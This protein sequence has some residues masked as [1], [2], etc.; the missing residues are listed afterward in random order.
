[1]SGGLKSLLWTPCF[2][3]GARHSPGPF[4]RHRGSENCAGPGLLGGQ[5]EEAVS[6]LITTFSSV[7]W[8]ERLPW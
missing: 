1:M 3:R 5:K 2:F 6:P 7:P 8:M 4:A